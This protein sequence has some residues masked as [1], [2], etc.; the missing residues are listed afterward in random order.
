MV[1]SSMIFGY[2]CN[3]GQYNLIQFFRFAILCYNMLKCFMVYEMRQKKDIPLS[4]I[5]P[6]YMTTSFLWVHFKRDN[7]KICGSQ[8]HNVCAHIIKNNR[9]IPCIDKPLQA[10]NFNGGFDLYICLSI[11]KIENAKSY[12]ICCFIQMFFALNQRMTIE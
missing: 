7:V 8:L 4:Y 6:Y 9:F 10:H 2:R 12:K 1:F 5:Q 11:L 3:K